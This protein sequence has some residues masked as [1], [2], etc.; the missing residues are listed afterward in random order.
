MEVA[1]FV[2][3][4]FRLLFCPTSSP[5]CGRNC[6]N[7]YV[8]FLIEAC[9]KGC[10][11]SIGLEAETNEFDVDLNCKTSCNSFTDDALKSAC[12]DGCVHIPSIEVE[13]PT[14]RMFSIFNNQF[15]SRPLGAEETHAPIIAVGTLS[16]PQVDEDTNLLMNVN[17]HPDVELPDAIHIIQVTF[18]D[19]ANFPS[20]VRYFC[21]RACA[22]LD[23]MATDPIF[24]AS[25]V[26]IFVAISGYLIF[27]FS[28]F[29]ARCAR[30]AVFR[31]QYQPILASFKSSSMHVNPVTLQ[32][33]LDAEVSGTGGI[34]ENGEAAA[35]AD[36]CMK[37]CRSSVGLEAKTNESAVNLKCET[38]CNDFTDDAL[39]SACYGGCTHI[40]PI[41]AESPTSKMPLFG[42]LCNPFFSSFF[43]PCEIAETV[44]PPD[45]EKN[46]AHIIPGGGAHMMD[47]EDMSLL[48]NDMH[49]PDVEP[50]GTVNMIQM[51][52]GGDAVDVPS[53]ARDF[54]FRAS[55]ALRHIVTHP[56][57]MASVIVMFIT[58]LSLLVSVCSLLIAR[59]ARRAV[60]QRHYQWMPTFESPFMRV[61]PVTPQQSSNDE[62]PELP[63]KEPII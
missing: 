47:G 61:S 1:L 14:S 49:I 25:I 42:I 17:D 15:F 36:A 29:S 8:I 45:V 18:C 28:L 23:H 5:D 3:M 48:T 4:L 22:I 26:V 34:I 43:R 24:M 53:F 52:L 11:S 46:P 56:L 20:F 31:R 37:G 33:S 50:P 6:K 27:V 2:L 7:K 58:S 35:L 30:K 51:P 12:Y 39:K 62:A 59:R 32:S 19:T 21:F 40:A 60:S 16:R 54:Y 9:M 55:S 38:S 41:K 57:F 44:T 13:R 63:P 10:H